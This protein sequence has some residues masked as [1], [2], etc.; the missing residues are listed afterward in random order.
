M[1]VTHRRPD[2]GMAEPVL[3]LDYRLGASDGECAEC[4]AQIV[5]ADRTQAG[6]LLGRDETTAER[7]AV[8]IHAVLTREDQ[9]VVAGRLTSL[10][11]ARH[12]FGYLRHHRHDSAVSRLRRR[13]LAVRVAAG[14]SDRRALEV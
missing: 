1:R 14:Y 10:G 11:Q 8:Q 4:M 2:F 5:E 7:R 13:Q 9:V 12:R 6:S 3:Q